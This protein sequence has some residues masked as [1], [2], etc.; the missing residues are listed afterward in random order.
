MENEQFKEIALF[1]FSLIAPLVNETYEGLSKMQY[2]REIS[3]KVHILPDGKKVTYSP[4][5]IKRWYLSYKRYGIDSLMPKKRLDAGK[6]RVLNQ[7][8]I[9]KIHNLKEQYPYI[10]GKMIHHKLVEEGFIKANKVSLASVQRYI[11][12]HHLKRRQLEPIE[13]RAYEM[14]FA[15]DCWQG[16]TSHGPKIIVGNKKVQTYLISI[17]DD[18]SRLIVHAEF[19]FHDNAIN[20]QAV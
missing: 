10:T 14:E 11:R 5:S 19:F 3:N 9:T 4:A 8:A 15:N 18:A 2:F 12:D 17:M 1:R 16:D 13:R 7:E 6:P 20:M